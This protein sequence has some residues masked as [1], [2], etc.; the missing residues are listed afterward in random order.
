V[1]DVPLRLYVNIESTAESQQ[2]NTNSWLYR[3]WFWKTLDSGCKPCSPPN[4]K[5][6]TNIHQTPA[7]IVLM[8]V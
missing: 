6:T 7:I 2:I 5:N 1:V 3:L 8:F 4:N